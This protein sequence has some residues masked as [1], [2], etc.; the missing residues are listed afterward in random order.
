MG[1]GADF[2]EYTAS[3]VPWIKEEIMS[4]RPFSGATLSVAT[5]V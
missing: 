3:P 1:D 5:F 2:A 4:P